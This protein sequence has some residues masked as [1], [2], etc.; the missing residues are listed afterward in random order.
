LEGRATPDADP[1]I[2]KLVRLTREEWV[3]LFAALWWLP[4]TSLSLRINGYQKTLNSF[5]QPEIGQGSGELE[6]LA[7]AKRI[8]RMVSIAV[9]YGPFR[10]K[11][12]CRSLVVIRMMRAHGLQADLVFGAA[13]EG[14]Q[15]GAHAWVEY[16]GEVVNDRDDVDAVFGQFQLPE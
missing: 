3:H 7:L 14:K 12:L 10:V 13:L 8:S 16:G 1:K 6:G 2:V 5:S 11:C 9:H 15:F 4:I